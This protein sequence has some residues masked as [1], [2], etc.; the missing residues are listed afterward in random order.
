MI[1][2]I[3]CIIMLVIKQFRIGPDTGPRSAVLARGLRPKGNTAD[4]EP[5]TG[6]VQNYLINDNFIN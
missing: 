3:N 6:P 2:F 4:R 5:V 1:L